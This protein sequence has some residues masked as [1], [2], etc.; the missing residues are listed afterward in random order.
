MK[1]IQPAGDLFTTAWTL[2][3]ISND[4][5]D[6]GVW[7]FTLQATLQNYPTIAPAKQVITGATV[8]DPC[9]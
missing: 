9:P 7:T 6:A 3:A 1:M 4:L 8:I 2:E 5:A